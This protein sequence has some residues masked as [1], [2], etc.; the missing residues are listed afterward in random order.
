MDTACCLVTQSMWNRS[1]SQYCHYFETSADWRN[2]SDYN[3]FIKGKPLFFGLWLKEMFF[4][5]AFCMNF[6]QTRER[7]AGVVFSLWGRVRV[8][9]ERNVVQETTTVAGSTSS[10][11]S[12]VGLWTDSARCSQENLQVL[13][14]RWK[15]KAESENSCGL[16]NVLQLISS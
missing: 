1:F 4:F 12:A 16:T 7:A 8:I 15:M 11:K 5:R 9:K 6:C 2:K 14:L 10:L 13:W 3:N